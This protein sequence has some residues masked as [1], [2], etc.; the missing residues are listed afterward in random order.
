MFGDRFV[1]VRHGADSDIAHRDAYEHHILHRD[2]SGGNVLMRP[3][4]TM[5]QG[6]PLVRVAGL[7]ADW[8]MAQDVSGPRTCRQAERTASVFSPD[9]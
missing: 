1:L 3:M 6:Y 9:R 7:L 5:A 8:E 2:V 4:I